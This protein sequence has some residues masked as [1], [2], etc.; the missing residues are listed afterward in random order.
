VLSPVPVCEWASGYQQTIRITCE[1]ERQHRSPYLFPC[2]YMDDSLSQGLSQ[3]EIH[4]HRLANKW[5]VTNCFTT[6]TKT[7]PSSP[8]RE[9]TSKVAAQLNRQLQSL[10]DSHV[11][12]TVIGQRVQSAILLRNIRV[13]HTH[14]NSST[15]PRPLTQT[16]QYDAAW[17]QA[18]FGSQHCLH[19]DDRLVCLG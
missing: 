15:Q 9:A 3:V 2:H 7:Q 18:V 13:C 4:N 12:T 14:V 5:L 1:N 11:S 19:L 10:R 8:R 16:T 6:S 17:Y